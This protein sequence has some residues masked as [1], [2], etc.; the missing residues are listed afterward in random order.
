MKYQLHHQ[1]SSAWLQCFHSSTHMGF[2]SKSL[3]Q[4]KPKRIHH[5]LI[6]RAE[7]F[8]EQQPIVVIE[9]YYKRN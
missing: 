4:R 9:A 8:N 5:L 7:I 1:T 3:A 6:N 2:P